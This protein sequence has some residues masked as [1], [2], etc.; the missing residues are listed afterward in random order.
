MSLTTD[1]TRVYGSGYSYEGSGN[2]EGV[3]A[4]DGA[5]AD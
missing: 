2:Y 4:V 5:R 1:A 3:F